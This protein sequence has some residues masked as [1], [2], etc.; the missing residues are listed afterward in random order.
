M[1]YTLAH[2]SI[3]NAQ[4]PAVRLD[5]FD[6]ARG[7]LAHAGFWRFHIFVEYTQL[8]GMLN[9]KHAVLHGRDA[10]H[11]CKEPSAPPA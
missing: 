7:L 3:A 5:D 6:L 2:R 11:R 10:R 9:K 8:R 1:V 4:A